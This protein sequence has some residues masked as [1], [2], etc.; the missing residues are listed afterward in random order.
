MSNPYLK[1]ELVQYP[2]ILEV[3]KKHSHWYKLEVF[4]FY[5]V[6]SFM[7]LPGSFYFLRDHS[8]WI[9]LAVFVIASVFLAMVTYTKDSQSQ[10]SLEIHPSKIR[11]YRCSRHSFD[12]RCTEFMQMIRGRF[13]KEEG[14]R[15]HTLR[16]AYNFYAYWV[17]MVIEIS[18]V[19]WITEWMNTTVLLGTVGLGLGVMAVGFELL[20]R[21]WLW[22]IQEESKGLSLYYSHHAVCFSNQIHW[23]WVDFYGYALCS[24]PPTYLYHLSHYV[25]HDR[26]DD[27]K[28]ALMQA[29]HKTDVVFS[30]MPYVQEVLASPEFQ[31]I[32]MKSGNA[33]DAWE[34]YLAFKSMPV[35]V[36]MTESFSDFS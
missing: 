13:E 24:L 9:I 17:F 14:N 28:I 10:R 26:W 2:D 4:S 19:L 18:L 25:V 20:R 11:Y 15:L 23:Q 1:D 16:C 35:V 22:M 6:L 3:I 34:A 8:I 21:R 36:E 29:A 5:D 30:K 33:R 32:S 27:F 31:T 7:L 12:E